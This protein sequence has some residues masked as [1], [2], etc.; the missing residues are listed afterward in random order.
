MFYQPQYKNINSFIYTQYNIGSN[1]DPVGDERVYS[2]PSI[3]GIG[4]NIDE[5][6]S[7]VEYTYWVINQIQYPNG[8]TVFT[9]HNPIIK[10]LINIS[11]KQE[12]IQ[13]VWSL[14]TKDILIK[15]D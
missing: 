12:Q 5:F 11:T 13:T 15:R 6:A 7:V 10:R 14:K 1:A 2:I 8:I 9:L 4:G 3:T